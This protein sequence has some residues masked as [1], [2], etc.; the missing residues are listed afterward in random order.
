AG[1]LD[2]IKQ[3][4]KIIAGT[5]S[6]LIPFEFI[7]DGKYV[8]YDVDLLHVIAEKWGVK[9]EHVDLPW[10]GILPGLQAKKFDLVATAVT[11]TE[12]RGGRGG[13]L[14]AGAVG[15]A[16]GE[17]GRVRD[18]VPH[19]RAPLLRLGL[20]EGGRR[21]AEGGRRDLHRAEEERHD[22]GAAEEVVRL[23]DGDTERG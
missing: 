18:E 4:G 6:G 14:H 17:V 23:H 16:Q 20:P 3:R 11:I 12:Q 7:R 19:R 21:P 1:T 8:G 10:Q 22:G 9:V 15:A 13:R 5:E 2:D